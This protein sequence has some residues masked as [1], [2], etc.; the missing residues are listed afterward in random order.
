MANITIKVMTEGVVDS[1]NRGSNCILIE[2]ISNY[3]F[4]AE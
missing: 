3:Q 1:A 4:D 2:Q